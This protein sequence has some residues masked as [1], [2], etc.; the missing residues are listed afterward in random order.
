MGF[1]SSGDGELHQMQ[2]KRSRNAESD[3]F[4]RL[5]D[6]MRLPLVP[7]LAAGYWAI[8]GAGEHGVL[9]TARPGWEAMT[10]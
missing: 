2:G 5:R 7:K 10:G 6:G 4:V 8:C 9:Q 1:T 3:S